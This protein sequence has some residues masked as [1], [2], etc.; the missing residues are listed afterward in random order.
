ML[1]H[2]QAGTTSQAA[3]EAGDPGS[4][5]PHRASLVPDAVAGQARDRPYSCIIWRLKAWIGMVGFFSFIFF[6]SSVEVVSAVSMK[7]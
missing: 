1:P 2:P 5:F 4:A 6:F 3:C 7:G